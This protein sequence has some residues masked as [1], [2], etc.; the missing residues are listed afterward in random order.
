MIQPIIPGKESKSIETFVLQRVAPVVNH[1]PPQA[2]PQSAPALNAEAGAEGTMHVNTQSAT[3]SS[4]AGSTV[5][6]SMLSN[7]LTASITSQTTTPQASRNYSVSNLSAMVDEKHANEV[8]ATQAGVAMEVQ[9][10]LGVASASAATAKG[11]PVPPKPVTLQL[12]PVEIEDG[13]TLYVSVLIKRDNRRKHNS[14]AWFL[15]SFAPSYDRSVPKHCLF[16]CS[17]PLIWV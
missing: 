2:P 1:S 6:Q 10:A 11:P 7:P 3:S 5:S 17:Q 14:H 16:V 12:V 9:S 4:V 8:A 15:S 13:K